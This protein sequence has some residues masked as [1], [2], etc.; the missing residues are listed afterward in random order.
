MSSEV[1]EALALRL[2]AA[3]GFVSRELVNDLARAPDGRALLVQHLARLREKKV[4]N[5]ALVALAGLALLDR[6][7]EPNKATE[8]SLAGVSRG[9]EPLVRSGQLVEPRRIVAARALRERGDTWARARSG[10]FVQGLEKLAAQTSP[11]GVASL[12]PED[13]VER[14]APKVGRNDPCPCGS[15][16]KFK[17][18]CESAPAEGP[19]PLGAILKTVRWTDELYA[20][21]P[22]RQLE[23][24][25]ETAF[26]EHLAILHDPERAK[27]PPR[28]EPYLCLAVLARLL[29][30]RASPAWARELALEMLEGKGHPALDRAAL[31]AWLLETKGEPPR[32]LAPRIAAALARGPLTV[33]GT[34][35]CGLALLDA[36]APVE[37]LDL[38][39]RPEGAASEPRLAFVRALS[40]YAAGD[41]ARARSELETLEGA[42]AGPDSAVLRAAVAELRAATDDPLAEDDTPAEVETIPEEAAPVRPVAELVRELHDHVSEA[43]SAPAVEP[44]R[45]PARLP[46]KAALVDANLGLEVQEIGVRSAAAVAH[47]R[48]ETERARREHDEARTQLRAL[49]RDLEKARERADRAKRGLARRE[50]ELASAERETPRAEAVAIARVLEEAEA[51]LLERVREQWKRVEEIAVPIVAALLSDSMLFVVPVRSEAYLEGTLDPELAVLA[52][53]SVATASDV[54]RQ[55]DQSEETVRPADLLGFLGIV[56]AAPL[57]RYRERSELWALALDDAWG[58]LAIGG[59]TRLAPVVSQLPP[60][61][62]RALYEQARVLELAPPEDHEEGEDPDDP[63]SIERAARRLGLSPFEVARA[64]GARSLWDPSGVVAPGALATL[65]L[66]SGRVAQRSHA[67]N[68]DASAHEL[69]AGDPLE[70]DPDPGRRAL[71]IVLRRLVRLG[72][73]GASHTR[74][75]NALRGAPPHLRGNVKH[76]VD[77]LITL[78]VFRSKPT[79][80][81]LHI[82][83]EPQRIRE[84][85]QFVLTGEYPWPR[86]STILTT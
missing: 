44:A 65:R 2:R 56:A 9:L 53:A 71:R 28:E 3:E 12:L 75:D 84:V 26:R 82:S 49:E 22:D 78:G 74:V 1:R 68:S 86:V 21:A 83:I 36:G 14:E 72:K 13:T 79:L 50:Q 52:H 4:E 57:A 10:E 33:V 23:L 29:Q 32:E 59:T 63:I 31:A 11:G 51:R 69:A 30:S 58:R 5:G 61:P 27:R 46:R 64:L 39:S 66:L 60:G 47:A 24:V 80:N 15:G 43:P 34:V 85:D 67:E 35:A 76:A 6:V 37:A 77:A 42:L 17:K 20:L 25:G 38:A 18:C 54:A 55:A 41:L 70:N 7:A 62:A 8:V 81:G 48:E 19:P 73:I 40:A 16:K 45:V